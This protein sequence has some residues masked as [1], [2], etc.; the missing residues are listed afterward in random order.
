MRQTSVPPEKSN[1]VTLPSGQ[2]GQVR[3]AVSPITRIHLLGTMRAASARHSDILPRGRKARA[4][5]GYLCFAG[6]AQVPRSRL[7]AMLWDRVSKDQARASLRQSHPRIDPGI[8]SGVEADHIGRSSH[9]STQHKR[10]LDRCN[11]ALVRGAG[12]SS[13][14]RS[15]LAEL[16]KGELL[17]E[18]DGISAGI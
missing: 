7:A 16:C 4:I 13:S 17:E 9:H 12:N 11:R 8:R 3:H 1:V 15:K 14:V 5:L 6:G 2:T 10:V 18:L